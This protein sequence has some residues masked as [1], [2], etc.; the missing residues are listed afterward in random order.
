MG[1]ACSRGGSVSRA[2]RIASL[3]GPPSAK[4]PTEAPKQ[5]ALWSL[6][7]PSED[8]TAEDNVLV[9]T[10]VEHCIIS[11]S[12]SLDRFESFQHLPQVRDTIL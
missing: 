11:I 2:A 7:N 6:R 12:D 1:S 9:E 8:G 3:Q 5:I 4:G 10:L